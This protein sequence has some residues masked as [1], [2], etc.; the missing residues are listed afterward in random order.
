MLQIVN[1]FTK[2]HIRLAVYT[3]EQ[4]SQVVVRILTSEIQNIYLEERG[5]IGIGSY[6]S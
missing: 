4:S 3:G 6:E 1:K 2:P 5:V